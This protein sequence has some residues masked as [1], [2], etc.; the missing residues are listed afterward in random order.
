MDGLYRAD[1]VDVCDAIEAAAACDRCRARHS[2][3]LLSSAPANAPIVVPRE[4]VP[5]VDGQPPNTEIDEDG[6]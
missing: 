6:G 1:G 4:R 5:W 3:A 2:P